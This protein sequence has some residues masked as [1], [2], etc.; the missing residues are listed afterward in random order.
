MLSAE[1]PQVDEDVTLG[2]KISGWQTDCGQLP[3]EQ[4]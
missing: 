1:L 2:C 3:A 4:D